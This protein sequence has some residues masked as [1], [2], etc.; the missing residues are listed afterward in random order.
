MTIEKAQKELEAA[1]NRGDDY[2]AEFWQG[3]VTML[4]TCK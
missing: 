1:R 3:I 4:E 2:A